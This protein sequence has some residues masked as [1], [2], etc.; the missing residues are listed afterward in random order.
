LFVTLAKSLNTPV[1][2]GWVGR[3]VA[4]GWDLGRV[5]K[6]VECPKCGRT[7]R[8][9]VLKATARGRAYYYLCVRHGESERCVLR[10]LTQEEVEEYLSQRVEGPQVRE[11]PKVEAQAQATKAEERV[12]V[13]R[14]APVQVPITQ[15][16]ESIARL[17]SRVQALEERL[18][19][20]EEARA[21]PAPRVEELPEEVRAVVERVR[22]LYG[23]RLVPS[24]APADIERLAW[25]LVKVLSSWGTL[26]ATRSQEDL[27]RFLSNIEELRARGVPMPEEVLRD[28]EA[29]AQAYTLTGEWKLR[30]FINELLRSCVEHALLSQLGQLKGEVERELEAKLAA[31]LEERV[32]EGVRARLESL[33]ERSLAITVE[34]LEALRKVAINKKG[35]TREESERARRVL[36]EIVARGREAGRVTVVFGDLG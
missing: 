1:L 18:A 23:R 9:Q 28:L 7:G 35:F 15:F 24:A 12:E 25:Y 3:A 10:P 26:R 31:R 16:F 29:A 19:K 36:H 34:D 27:D 20:L 5:G 21:Q 6:T 4:N 17:E 22:S 8:V 13:H 33:R 2:P 32:E 11:T 30:G 14:P